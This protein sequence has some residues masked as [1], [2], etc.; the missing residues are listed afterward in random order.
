MVNT[1]IVTGGHLSLSLCGL[2]YAIYSTEVKWSMDCSEWW[3][4]WLVGVVTLGLFQWLVYFLICST[5]EFF[6]SDDV[7]V[8]FEG[9]RVVR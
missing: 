3:W 1:L 4:V 7:I 5:F 9:F 2:F 8:A 6:E